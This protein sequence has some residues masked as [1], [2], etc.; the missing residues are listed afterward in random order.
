MGRI[1]IGLRNKD[2]II[3]QL[4]QC[5]EIKI[6]NKENPPNRFFNSYING[7]VNCLMWILGFNIISPTRDDLDKTAE[8]NNGIEYQTDEFYETQDDEI[9]MSK[10]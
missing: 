3:V 4:I 8:K 6:K 10:I 9:D 2:E 1:K 5:Q 7:W